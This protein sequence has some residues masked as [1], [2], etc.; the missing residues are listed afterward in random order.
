MLILA[1]FCSLQH[2]PKSYSTL[3]WS[4]T[5]SPEP[6]MGSL[7]QKRETGNQLFYHL[8]ACTLDKHFLP[9]I[10]SLPTSFKYFPFVD[11]CHLQTDLSLS[12]SKHSLLSSVTVYICQL[13]FHFLIFSSYFRL[14]CICFLGYPCTH[15]SIKYMFEN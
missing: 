5:G 12:R 6:L 1:A 4:V 8:H 7:P 13:I 9:L 14:F 10:I 11:L 3:F 2:P 15:I